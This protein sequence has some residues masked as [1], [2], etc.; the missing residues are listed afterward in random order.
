M[1]QQQ[2]ILKQEIKQL[3]L[4]KSVS[5]IPGCKLNVFILGLLVSFEAKWAVNITFASLDMP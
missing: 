3:F 1:M 2:M 4:L 5:T